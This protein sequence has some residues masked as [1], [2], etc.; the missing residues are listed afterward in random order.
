MVYMEMNYRDLRMRPQMAE[1]IASAFAEIEAALGGGEE[2]DGAVALIRTQEDVIRTSPNA[3]PLR[4]VHM[5]NWWLGK[6]GR[7]HLEAFPARTGY[8]QGAAAGEGGVG[9]LVETTL[10]IPQKSIVLCGGSNLP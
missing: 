3:F 9:E 4:A 7:P 2:A 5:A 1:E 6:N 10:E 8:E